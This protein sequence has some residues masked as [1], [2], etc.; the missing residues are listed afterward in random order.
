MNCQA[1]AAAKKALIA[2][3][4]CFY[5][6]GWNVVQLVDES[7]CL[8]PFTLSPAPLYKAPNIATSKAK[9]ERELVQGGVGGA[10][11]TS[12]EELS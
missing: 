11:P 3:A 12:S 4:V 10:G 1:T 8:G 2:W 9:G 7:C 5:A 6:A